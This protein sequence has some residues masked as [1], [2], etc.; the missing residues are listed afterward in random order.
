M[1]DP[2]VWRGQCRSG[3]GVVLVTVLA[4]AWVCV[5]DVAA[6]ADITDLSP[7]RLLEQGKALEQQKQ[8]PAAIAVY[9]RY[10]AARP[11]NDEV[12]AT[13]AKLLSW[14]GQWD[15][16][17][18]LYRDVLTRHPLDDDSRVALARVLSWQ[19]NYDEAQQEYE[20]VLRDDPQQSDA[21]A[22]LGDVLLWSGHP[23]QAIPYYQRVVEATG[24]PEVA[25][26]LRTL[27]DGSSAQSDPAISRPALEA[28]PVRETED[29][30]AD[31]RQILAHGRQLE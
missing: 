25:A 1:S 24:D 20:Q 13:L 5:I 19:K 30:S 8:F 12:R 23:D 9:R 22:G 10:L 16:A 7:R 21:L 27:H 14:Q 26:R 31:E 3:A 4:M 15:E 18:A 17:S 11:E 6:Q 29:G 28:P 2:M